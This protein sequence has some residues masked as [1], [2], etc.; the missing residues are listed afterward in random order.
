MKKTTVFLFIFLTLA[1]VLLSVGVA[2]NDLRQFDFA[3]TTKV[4]SLLPRSLDRFMS[5]FSILGTVEITTLFL[6]GL[7]FLFRKLNWFK[8]LF[9]YGV[10]Q[11]IELFSKVFVKQ[12][13]PPSI[14]SRYNLG[15]VFPSSYVQTGNS[16]P[17]GHIFRTT[18]ILLM[19]AVLI[20]RSRKMLFGQKLFFGSVILIFLVIMI[21]SRIYLGEHWASDVFAGLLLGIEFSFFAILDYKWKGGGR[22]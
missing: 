15:F 21:L 2:N 5:F 8:V 6:L 1:F 10:G 19:L 18:F 11:F 7:L 4:Q 12:P 13:N 14:F 22:K 20:F 16:Y 9:F 3:F 17:S